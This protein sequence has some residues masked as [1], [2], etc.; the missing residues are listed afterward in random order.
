M[1]NA[2]QAEVIVDLSIVTAVQG[3]LAEHKSSRLAELEPHK[4]LLGD[5]WAEAE[6]RRGPGGAP[7]P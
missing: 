2:V 1:L 4:D 7:R 5:I 3:F 6:A